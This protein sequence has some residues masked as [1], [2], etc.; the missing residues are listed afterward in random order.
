MA[1][2]LLAVSPGGTWAP[3]L[4]WEVAP[5]PEDNAAPR[6]ATKGSSTSSGEGLPSDVGALAWFNHSRT[7]FPDLAAQTAV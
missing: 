5:E 1:V 2:G 3:V 6:A 7:V 4:G